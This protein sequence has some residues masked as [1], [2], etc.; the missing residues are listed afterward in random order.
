[1]TPREVKSRLNRPVRWRGKEYLFTGC[2]IRLRDGEFTYQAELTERR[3]S[4]IT[5]YI[6][7]LDEIE[8]V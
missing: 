2:I 1:M 3:E 5:V 6:T 7:A 4:M 8:E